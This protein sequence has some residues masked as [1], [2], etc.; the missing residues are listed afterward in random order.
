MN[1]FCADV[2]SLTHSLPPMYSI[3]MCL[4]RWDGWLENAL[5]DHL[6][7]WC[8]AW[9]L[10]LKIWWSQVTNPFTISRKSFMNFSRNTFLGHGWQMVQRKRTQRDNRFC[11]EGSFKANFEDVLYA[12]FLLLYHLL[13]LLVCILGTVPYIALYIYMI[14]VILGLGSYTVYMHMVYIICWFAI[15]V[16]EKLH[17]SHCFVLLMLQKYGQPATSRGKYP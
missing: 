10:M 16:S 12:N 7:S 4:I 13:M 17:Q 2:Y 15:L 9:T 8:G 6:I 5:N 14:H 3:S 1:H 11:K